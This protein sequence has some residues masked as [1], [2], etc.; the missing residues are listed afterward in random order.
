MASLY[1]EYLTERT[2]I[3]IIET[4]RGFVTYEELEDG[5]YLIDMFI[6][7]VFRG[8][9]YAKVLA[10][11]VEKASKELG[12]KKVYTSVSPQA[13]GATTSLKIIT[14]YGFKLLNASPEL[15]MFVKE[16]Y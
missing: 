12:F 13:N 1:A 2:N 9:G 10:T 15:I 6:R 16:I 11:K 14:G 7:K 5:V 8:T 4:E 3:K